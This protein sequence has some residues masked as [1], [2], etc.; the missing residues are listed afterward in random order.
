MFTQ[1]KEQLFQ[2]LLERFKGEEKLNAKMQEVGFEDLFSIKFLSENS[3]FSSLDD[4]LFRSGF[5]I[6]SPMEIARIPVDKWDEYIAKHCKCKTWH[7]LGKLAMIDWMQ[8]V[9]SQEKGDC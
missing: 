7:E 3:D 9:I 4:I 2:Q 5:G 6:M 1:E 8:N